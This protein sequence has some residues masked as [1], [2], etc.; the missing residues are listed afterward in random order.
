MNKR[1]FSKYHEAMRKKH[2]EDKKIREWVKSG[3]CEKIT[4][5]L[6]TKRNAKIKPSELPF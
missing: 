2:E 1:N 6:N 5:K 4:N 3:E